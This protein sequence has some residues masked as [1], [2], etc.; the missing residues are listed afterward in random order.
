VPEVGEIVELGNVRLE[1]AEADGTRI[2][3]LRTPTAGAEEPPR[4]DDAAE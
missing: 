4:V 3:E 1:V 2:A